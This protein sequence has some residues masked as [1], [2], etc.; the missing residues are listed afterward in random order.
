M[1]FQDEAGVTKLSVE[2]KPLASR[3]INPI[4]KGAVD[5]GLTVH[6]SKIVCRDCDS[7]VSLGVKHAIT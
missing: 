4:S 3:G 6:A 5:F 1:E 2:G 7:C